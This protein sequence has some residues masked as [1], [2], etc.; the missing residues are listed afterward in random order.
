MTL[1]LTIL[2]SPGHVSHLVRCTLELVEGC[3]M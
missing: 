2:A 1:G 3:E